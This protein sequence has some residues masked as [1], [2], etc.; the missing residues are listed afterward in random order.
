MK[1][2]TKCEWEVGMYHLHWYPIRYRK[3]NYLLT[4]RPCEYQAAIFFV[5]DWVTSQIA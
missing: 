5:K 4:V 2:E 3:G 1:D